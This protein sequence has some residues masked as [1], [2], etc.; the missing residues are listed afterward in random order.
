[1]RARA[2]ARVRLL[3]RGRLFNVFAITIHRHFWFLLKWKERRNDL[4]Y[5]V[6]LCPRTRW[7]R[8]RGREV[9]RV[10]GVH[11]SIW[12]FWTYGASRI[13]A[14]AHYM[15]FVRVRLC[16]IYLPS[17]CVCSILTSF[18]I[19]SANF[20]VSFLVVIHTL[21]HSH[22][23]KSRV[24]CAFSFIVLPYRFNDFAFIWLID[25]D[26]NIVLFIIL[27]ELQHTKQTR[28]V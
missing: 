22:E 23:H 8:G 4:N 21:T 15:P 28:F 27:F 10:D 26:T 7:R 9:M 17:S 19:Y 1:M 12:I 14:L 11:S 25:R 13:F 18:V 16:S 5:F 6:E 3:C 24:K 20:H 2:P